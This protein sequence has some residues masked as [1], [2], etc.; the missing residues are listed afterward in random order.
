MPKIHSA[1]EAFIAKDNDETTIDECAAQINRIDEVLAHIRSMSTGAIKPPECNEILDLELSGSATELSLTGKKKK[2][3]SKLKKAKKKIEDKQKIIEDKQKKITEATVKIQSFTRMRLAKKAQEKEKAKT[4]IAAATTELEALTG[5]LTTLND[6]LTQLPAMNASVANVRGYI[7]GLPDIFDDEASKADL[8]L[9]E[10]YASK[11]PDDDVAAYV[12]ALQPLTRGLLFRALLKQ[13]EKIMRLNE[14]STQAMSLARDTGEAA[15]YQTAFDDITHVVNT[16]AGNAYNLLTDDER[17]DLTHDETESV[18]AKVKALADENKAKFKQHKDTRD[19]SLGAV[20]SSTVQLNALLAAKS[21]LADAITN[22]NSEQSL[23][24]RMKEHLNAQAET[25]AF[26]NTRVNGDF[27]TLIE[28]QAYLKDSQKHVLQIALERTQKTALYESIKNALT[29]YVEQDTVHE[30]PKNAYFQEP[31]NQK[32]TAQETAI[33]SAIK[34]LPAAVKEAIGYKDGTGTERATTINQALLHKAKEVFEEI[35][36]NSTTNPLQ[37]LLNDLKKTKE[38]YRE[39][40]KSTAKPADSMTSHSASPLVFDEQTKAKTVQLL[41]TSEG[42]Q[43]KLASS[44]G[45][46]NDRLKIENSQFEHEFEKNGRSLLRYKQGASITKEQKIIELL[47][48]KMAVDASQNPP[49]KT[50]AISSMMI[51][52]EAVTEADIDAAIKSTATLS[53][54]YDTVYFGGKILRGADHLI[55]EDPELQTKY[56]EIPQDSWADSGS[57]VDLEKSEKAF[58]IYKAIL[59]P[60]SIDALKNELESKNATTD[61]KGHIEKC[62]ILQELKTRGHIGIQDTVWTAVVAPTLKATDT[63]NTAT[64]SHAVSVLNQQAQEIR[65]NDTGFTVSK[66]NLRQKITRAAF[67]YFVEGKISG[68][69]LKQVYDRNHPIFQHIEANKIDP[70]IKGAIYQAAIMAYQL[71]RTHSEVIKEEVDLANLDT[72][73]E[74]GRF[75]AIDVTRWGS[76]FDGN[77]IDS[78]IKD[79]AIMAVRETETYQRLQRE[80]S[81]CLYQPEST[82][83]KVEIRGDKTNAINTQSLGNKNLQDGFLQLHGGIQTQHELESNSNLQDIKRK[84]SAVKEMENTVSESKRKKWFSSFNTDAAKK[85]LLERSN[86]I[87]PRQEAIIP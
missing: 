19:K 34:A 42:S 49:I 30:D 86:Q 24:E 62:A 1:L 5:K 21:E 85:E 58:K 83:S 6:Q 67:R 65:L 18:L 53:N 29:T 44:P 78:K 36:Q 39:L 64:L 54:H 59:R 82:L 60:M 72:L 45:D 84:L 73:Q 69:N 87:I 48:G 3:I 43:Y 12:A 4:T 77:T 27:R 10:S 35:K 71:N 37:D 20:E 31:L 8:E 25:K 61:I 40:I 16:A 47:K 33:R 80:I 57:C 23:F 51:G 28:H 70:T 41:N 38:G 63:P 68:D 66:A 74:D 46:G 22:R 81:E 14:S 15:A 9:L 11:Y 52:S 50:L 79:E 2:I 76:L 17:V 32:L 55:S 13:H 26:E 56:R 75:K 7:E